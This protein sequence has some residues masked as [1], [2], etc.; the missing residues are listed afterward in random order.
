MAGD[1]QA[2][3]L[4]ERPAFFYHLG[5]VAYEFGQANCYYGQFY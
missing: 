3:S 4:S 2:S 1:L 5:D